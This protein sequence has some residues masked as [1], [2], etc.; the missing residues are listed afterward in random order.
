MKCKMWNNISGNFLSFVKVRTEVPCFQSKIFDVNWRDK[1]KCSHGAPGRSRGKPGSQELM[2]ASWVLTL[3]FP[4]AKNQQFT[5]SFSPMVPSWIN[6]TDQL[7]LMINPHFLHQKMWFGPIFCSGLRFPDCSSQLVLRDKTAWKSPAGASKSLSLISIVLQLDWSF[8]HFSLSSLFS[9]F[10][11]IA[12]HVLSLFLSLCL[13]HSLPLLSVCVC[14]QECVQPTL[15][16][17]IFLL[18][19]P[20]WFP[21]WLHQTNTRFASVSTLAHSFLLSLSHLSHA[22]TNAL[23]HN[24]H[25]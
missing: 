20:H 6:P 1:V 11:L 19:I 10:W 21:V 18:S 23:T 13:S 2:L 5:W 14:V 3:L 7:S 22:H 12:H 25:I 15:G 4:A 17:G 24:T 16:Q 9:L 8:A